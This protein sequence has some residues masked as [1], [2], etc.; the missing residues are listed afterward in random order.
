M[1]STEKQDKLLL[2]SFPIIL[3]NSNI[4]QKY[5]NKF[6]LSVRK[7]ITFPKNFSNDYYPEFLDKLM[8]IDILILT[9]NLR[10]ILSFKYI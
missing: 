7:I 1:G 8:N 4:M 9:F 2:N 10:D 6:N 3:E 5:L